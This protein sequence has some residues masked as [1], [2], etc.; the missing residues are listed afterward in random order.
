[1][2]TGSAVAFYRDLLAR[3]PGAASISVDL[4][5]ALFA[6]GR[7][8]EALQ[9][10]D[11]GLAGDPSL[12][13]GWL[14]RGGVCKA[15][16]RF[17]EAADAFE[18]ANRLMPERAPVL[19]ALATVNAEIGRLKQAEDWLLRAV[20]CD[21]KCTEAYANLSS[22][23]V[24]QGRFDLAE[25]ACR[26][27]LALSP[28][29]V[30]AHQNLAGILARSSS[31]QA[32]A[33]RDA[34]YRRQ[35]IFIEAAAH[36]Y[37]TVLVLCVADAANVPLRDLL[38]RERCTLIKWFVEYAPPGQEAALPPYD[39]VFNAIGEAEF[40]SASAPRVQ[41]FLAQCRRPLLNH[42]ARVART[43]RGDMQVLFGGLAD[44]VVPRVLRVSPGQDVPQAM[45]GSGLAPPVILRPIGSHGGEGA[46]RIDGWAELEAC[47]AHHDGLYVTE[48]VDCRGADGLYR[49]YRVIFVDRVPYAYHLAVSPRWLV[50]YW[51]AG[52]ED[53]AAHRAEEKR[54]LANPGAAIGLP[55]WQALAAIGARLD[56]DYGGI[57]FAVLSDGRLLLFEANATML[58]HTEDEAM[59]AYKNPAV[60]RIRD[61]FDAVVNARL[62]A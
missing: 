62:A 38:P 41:R 57:D 40:A 6:D 26:N 3:M 60:Q 27:A 8:E 34:A 19:V 61:A 15:L 55:A 30:V 11:A 59:F 53:N 42:P 17:A 43:G 39:F 46:R 23:Y 9:A 16:H 4:A 5:E 25:T 12:I 50:H 48:F 47:G 36:P 14:V 28:G 33:H 56:L 52:M 58:I 35:Q 29:L 54:F 45:R 10:L 1:M 51:T 44:V 18:R 32:R 20:A 24:R 49:K 21:P 2:S 37:R 13:R 7:R 22:V 31:Q